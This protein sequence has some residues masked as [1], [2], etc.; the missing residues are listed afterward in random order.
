MIYN[1]VDIYECHFFTINKNGKLQFTK[2]IF[3]EKTSNDFK[4]ISRLREVFSYCFWI[5]HNVE[6]PLVSKYLASVFIK[7]LIPKMIEIEKRL[8]KKMIAVQRKLKED[9]EKSTKQTGTVYGKVD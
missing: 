6:T 1:D 3:K 5:M 7:D 9:T 8:N 2:G 4:S